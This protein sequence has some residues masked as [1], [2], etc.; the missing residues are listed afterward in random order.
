MIEQIFTGTQVESLRITEPDASDF[1]VLV[2]QFPGKCDPEDLELD[3]ICFATYSIA[4]G[5]NPLVH[6][7]SLT[8]KG[9]VGMIEWYRENVGYS[10]DEDIGAPTPILELVDSVASHLLLREQAKLAVAVG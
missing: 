3:Y 8:L 9:R 5:V 7:A 10:P 4:D 6:I 1:L 2:S